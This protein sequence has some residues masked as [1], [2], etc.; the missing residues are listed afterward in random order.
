MGV[1]YAICI[2]KRTILSVIRR[3]NLTLAL[4]SGRLPPEPKTPPD[5]G[6][7]GVLF[8]GAHWRIIEQIQSNTA[9]ANRGEVGE[10]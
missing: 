3:V 1:P 6:P 7:G 5:S 8:F 2:K 10:K 4:Q 9:G